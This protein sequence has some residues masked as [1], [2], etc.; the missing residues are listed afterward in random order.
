MVVR[1]RAPFSE[2]AA[3]GGRS[4]VSSGSLDPFEKRNARFDRRQTFALQGRRSPEGS[5]DSNH[6]SRACGSFPSPA[7]SR[8]HPARAA[9]HSNTAQATTRNHPSLPPGSGPLGIDESILVSKPEPRTDAR[10][11]ATSRRPYRRIRGV[12]QR[13]HR[14]PSKSVS[15][16]SGGLEKA[17]EPPSFKTALSV[18][19][20]SLHAGSDASGQ[21][22][23]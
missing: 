12:P 3:L 6:G 10:P 23:R 1:L 5:S 17:T 14:L 7:I 15:S 11:D 21:G 4:S 18:H 2:L 13:R 22:S 8:L 19:M 9:S 20:G 16:G